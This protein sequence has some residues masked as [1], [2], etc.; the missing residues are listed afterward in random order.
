MFF[1]SKS[2]LVPHKVRL[3]FVDAMSFHATIEKA[4][5]VAVVGVLR[6]GQASAVMHKFLKLIWLVLAKVFDFHLLLSLLD[7][8]VLFGLGSSW[9]TLPRQ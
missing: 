8:G 1:K 6:E 7:I 9:E 2:I 5:N 3:L 4:N